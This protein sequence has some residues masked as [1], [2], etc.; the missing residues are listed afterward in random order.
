[1]VAFDPLLQPL[2]GTHSIEA[3]AGTGKTHSITLLWLR[4]LL[5]EGLR[6]DQVLVTTF[7]KAATAE[8]RERLLGSLKTALAH[9]QTL[10]SQPDRPR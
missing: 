2:A 6:V 3:S 8:L 7:T 1:M 4:L 9:T 10:L 5:E